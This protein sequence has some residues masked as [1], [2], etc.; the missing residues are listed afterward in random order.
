MEF[1]KWAKIVVVGCVALALTGCHSKR[2]CMDPNAVNDANAAYAENGV[3]TSGMGMESGFGDQAEGGQRQFA[4]NKNTYY[5][6]FDSNAVRDEDKADIESNAQHLASASHAKAMVEGHTDPRGSREYN[7]GLGERR[8]NSV[9]K[10]LT[11][12]GANPSQIRV[13]SYGAEKLAAAGH[14]EEDYQQDRRA[15]IVKAKN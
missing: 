6:D 7:I 3:Q 15:V 9:A 1:N 14:S 10:I 13:V 5:F 11:Q 8:A 4:S 12:K 2:R